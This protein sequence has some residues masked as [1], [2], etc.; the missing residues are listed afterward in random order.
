MKKN[1]G[2]G[3][4]AAMVML[5]AGLAAVSVWSDPTPERIV[6]KERFGSNGSIGVITLIGKEGEFVKSS[7][8]HSK[9]ITQRVFDVKVEDG[10]DGSR[11]IGLRIGSAETAPV[12]FVGGSGVFGCADCGPLQKQWLVE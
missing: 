4:F 9:T 10:G 6:L 12:H 5:A 3:V 7:P 11:H 1:F 8:D 2:S